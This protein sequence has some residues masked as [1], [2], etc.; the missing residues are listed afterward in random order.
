LHKVPSSKGIVEEFQK[1]LKSI[2][3]E[4]LAFF[5]E[6]PPATDQ[7]ESPVF[8]ETEDINS[9][10]SSSVNNSQNLNWQHTLRWETPS[11]ESK[12]GIQNP[13]K[14]SK[15]SHQ[16]FSRVVQKVS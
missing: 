15:K 12:K 11:V 16:T 13:A 9:L 10:F 1:S 8:V 2:A 3:I 4:T 14:Y 7:V 5:I 6:L